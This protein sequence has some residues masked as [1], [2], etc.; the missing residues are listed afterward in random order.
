MPEIPLVPA[1][2]RFPAHPA[3]VRGAGTPSPNRCR[4]SSVHN[5]ATT[6]AC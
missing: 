1:H 4:T 3:S 2:W 6:W 5:S